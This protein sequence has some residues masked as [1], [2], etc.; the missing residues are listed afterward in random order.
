MEGLGPLIDTDP[1]QLL[2]MYKIN[3][4][5]PLLLVQALVDPLVYCGGSVVNIGSVGVMGLP[6][7]G[8]YASSKVS[9]RTRSFEHTYHS[10]AMALMTMATGGLSS[11][12]R[13]IT[14]RDSSTRVESDH[15]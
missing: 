1:S 7:H 9:H 2:E 13:C 10:I 14:T 15:S 8:A 11:P 4:V 5:G 12:K 3:V 6:F